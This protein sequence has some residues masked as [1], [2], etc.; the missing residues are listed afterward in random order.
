[1]RALF[2]GSF[3]G[4]VGLVG[5][6]IVEWG[7]GGGRLRQTRRVGVLPGGVGTFCLDRRRELQDV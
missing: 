3:G 6:G 7:V 5:V 2:C 1:M 4:L